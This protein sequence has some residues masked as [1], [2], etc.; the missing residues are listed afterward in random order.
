MQIVLK[1]GID[2]HRL[3]IHLGNC[4]S[5]SNNKF[6]VIDI[7]L[8]SIIAAVAYLGCFLHYSFPLRIFL[9]G[10]SIQ[11]KHRFKRGYI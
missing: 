11:Q 5:V 2:V 3:R 1:L 7:T 4:P 9:N 6:I 8:L 10:N